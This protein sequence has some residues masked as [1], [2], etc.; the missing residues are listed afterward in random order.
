MQRIE[1]QCKLWT[2]GFLYIGVRHYSQW[3]D[4][5]SERC[6]TGLSQ[7]SYDFD[8]LHAAPTCLVPRGRT[9]VTAARPGKCYGFAVSHQGLEVGVA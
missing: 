6:S 5:A 3:Y 7:R 2:A 1:G 8:A 9:K 4:V